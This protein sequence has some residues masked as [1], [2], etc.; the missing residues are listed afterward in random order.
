MKRLPLQYE[1]IY[2]ERGVSSANICLFRIR[3]TRE[4]KTSR[5][6]SQIFKRTVDALSH[7]MLRP[8][9]ILECSLNQKIFFSLWGFRIKWVPTFWKWARRVHLLEHFPVSV[10]TLSP[11]SATSQ[12]LQSTRGWGERVGEIGCKCHTGYM[13]GGLCYSLNNELGVQKSGWEPEVYLAE[14]PV[15][16]ENV[17]FAKWLWG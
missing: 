10:D 9:K 15:W 14:P 16:W 3:A 1:S 17:V 6:V 8:H 12:H 7:K 4:L 11:K 2:S 5:K 13:L